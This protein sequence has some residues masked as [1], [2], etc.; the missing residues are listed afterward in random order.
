MTKAYPDSRAADGT[1]PARP[2]HTEDLAAV[3]QAA[4]ALL[5]EGVNDRRA[6]ANRPAL[7]TA[8]A[9][10]S[11]QVRTVVVRAFD[12]DA[13]TLQIHADRRSGKI[14]ELRVNPNAVLHVY[15]A[16]RDVQLRLACQVSVHCGGPLHDRAWSAKPQ[17]S[18]AYYTV[19]ATPGQPIQS[20]AEGGFSTGHDD[21]GKENFAV[22]EVR[23][24]TLEW[25]YIGPGGHRRARFDWTEGTCHG[26]WL[27]P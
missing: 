17:S 1:G 9:G 26:D 4:F 8:G 10:G 24:M 14:A 27:V 7:A 20:P 22:L 3:R 25:L 18:R 11:P 23:I 15:D 5:A 2:S 21:K 12:P 6:A 13:R 16:A 19:T